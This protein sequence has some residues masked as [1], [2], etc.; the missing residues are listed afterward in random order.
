MISHDCTNIEAVIHIVIRYINELL[1]F[2]L[3]LTLDT[4]KFDGA[5]TSVNL[6]ILDPFVEREHIESLVYTSVVIQAKYT[7]I[8]SIFTLNTHC[9]DFL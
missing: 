1:Q 6:D 7:T 9:I 4:T 5:T 3:S 8:F 2:C